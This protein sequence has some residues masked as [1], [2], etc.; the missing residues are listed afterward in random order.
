MPPNVR[1]E[2]ARAVTPSV[3]AAI[4]RLVQ[5]LSPSALGPTPAEL[6]E[7]VASPATRLLLARDTDDVIVGMLTVAL[8]RIA[9]GMCA[10]IEDVVVEERRRGRGI[11]EDLTRAA[12]R[13]AE[14]A[15]ADMLDLTSR[16]I[17]EA[18]NRLYRRMAFGAR[19]TNIYRLRL[20]VR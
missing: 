6:E 15:G 17:R 20:R 3:A 18:A 9:T 13:L 5:Q 8:Y 4:R 10:W 16:P 1:I 14:D 11:G 12:V 7:I 19:E 2:E